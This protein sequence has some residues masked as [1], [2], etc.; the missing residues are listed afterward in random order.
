MK[1]IIFVV[2]VFAVI[3]G[4]VIWYFQ[5]DKNGGGQTQ[6]Y[7]KESV[8]S[9]TPVPSSANSSASF[10]IEDLKVGT[11]KEARA[12]D[13]VEVNYLGTLTNGT[14]F[15]SSYDRKQPFDFHLGA[16]EVIKG[17][18]QGVVGMKIGGKRRLTIPPELGYGAA[19]AGTLIPPN[20]TLVFEVELLQIK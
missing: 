17:W 7:G 9:P 19:G 18:D 12:G 15:D 1:T 6:Q 11:G 8:S 10:K 3:I 5:S 16:G 14:K 4:G 20:A 2:I 13:T